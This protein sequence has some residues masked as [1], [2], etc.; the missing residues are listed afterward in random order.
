MDME[1]I[2]RVPWTERRMNLS[3]LEELKPKRSWEATIIWSRL[4]YFSH[5]MTAK[6]SLE[7]DMLG[8][9][10]GH[11]RQGNHSCDGFKASRKL[12]AYVWKLWKKQYKIGK[13]VS[14]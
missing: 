5:V 14:K 9:V 4:H 2:L 12:P 1:K 13:K 8:Q 7:Q 10:A 6:G 3:V 11:R